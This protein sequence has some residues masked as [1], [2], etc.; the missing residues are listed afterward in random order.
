[1]RAK[2]RVRDNDPE[3]DDP[4]TGLTACFFTSESDVSLLCLNCNSLQF[5][6]KHHCSFNPAVISLCSCFLDHWFGCNQVVVYTILSCRKY[7]CST[8]KAN[9]YD[10][11]SAKSIGS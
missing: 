3:R 10:M 4:H 9:T 5:C 6:L 2:V 1:M 8:T 7:S 11:F